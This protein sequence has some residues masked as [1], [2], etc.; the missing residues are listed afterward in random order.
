MLQLEKQYSD[1]LF[2]SSESDNR[3]VFEH[4]ESNRDL[5]GNEDLIRFPDNVES[6]HI[7][8]PTYMS[9]ADFDPLFE[10]KSKASQSN[11]KI[12]D[13]TK[14]TSKPPAICPRRKVTSLPSA[15]SEDNCLP[16]SVTGTQQRVSVIPASWSF[17]PD[18]NF[19]GSGVCTFKTRAVDR[20][21]KC[22]DFD[23]EDPDDPFSLCHLMRKSQKYQ[24]QQLQQQQYWQ[25]ND[26]Q[27]QISSS[28]SS[29]QE[30]RKVVM[31][32]HSECVSIL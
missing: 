28:E 24:A 12:E 3:E 30:V 10:M 6:T 15:S 7:S 5:E 19:D 22:F 14:K 13:E 18:T 25:K 16:Y 31:R 11:K 23:W 26:Q 27:K 1:P 17:S 20:D 8:N 29:S 21:D 32:N 4:E 2:C 9:L